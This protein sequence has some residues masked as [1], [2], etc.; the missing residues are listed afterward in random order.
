MSSSSA[1]RGFPSAEKYSVTL[2]RVFP[3][4][5]YNCPSFE[6]R[7]RPIPNTWSVR[8][9]FSFLIGIASFSCRVGPHGAACGP[10]R[11]YGSRD[12]DHAKKPTGGG[13]T[14][15]CASHDFRFPW[16]HFFDCPF[17]LKQSNMTCLI[18]P[19]RFYVSPAW[20][21]LFQPSSYTSIVP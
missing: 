13:K 17:H 15:P 3:W 16:I 8:L 20:V 19:V 21:Y 10:V 2:M 7:Y 1:C 12:T 14:A 5:K 6:Y 9:R 4:I 18:V 11:S